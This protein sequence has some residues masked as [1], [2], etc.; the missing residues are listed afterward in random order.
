MISKL[1]VKLF[2]YQL[3]E[4]KL[5]LK[6]REECYLKSI[7]TV[8]KLIVRLIRSVLQK[9]IIFLNPVPFASWL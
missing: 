9:P 2:N 4:W 7:R 8:K 6:S 5:F 1:T 3:S